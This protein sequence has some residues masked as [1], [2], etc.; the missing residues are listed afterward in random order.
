MQPC[1]L[2]ACI[3]LSIPGS[4]SESIEEMSL[5]GSFWTALNILV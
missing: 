5:S 1:V 4:N 3:V 2:I